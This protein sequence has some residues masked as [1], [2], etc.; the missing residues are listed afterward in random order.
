MKY[1]T[2]PKPLRLFYSASHS[3]SGRVLKANCSGPIFWNHHSYGCPS[4]YERSVNDQ[5]TFRLSPFDNCVPLLVF[6]VPHAPY[7]SA[8]RGTNGSDPKRKRNPSLIPRNSRNV[9]ARHRMALEEIDNVV[10]E[11][12]DAQ[13]SWK[14]SRWILVRS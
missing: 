6:P 13:R 10:N 9:S 5:N 3:F 12:L 1:L 11:L 4:A 7:I 8:R 14:G 2:F